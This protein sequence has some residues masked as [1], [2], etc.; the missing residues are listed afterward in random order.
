MGI[1]FLN[2]RA[3]SKGKAIILW[4]RKQTTDVLTEKLISL[5]SNLG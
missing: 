3:C 2:L 1:S 5:K 4:T